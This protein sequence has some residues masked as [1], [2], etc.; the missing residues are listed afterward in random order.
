MWPQTEAQKEAVFR[1]IERVEAARGRP[2]MTVVAPPK[3]FWEA[4]WY[5]QDYNTKNKL[6]L[7]AAAGVFYCNNI[8]HGSFPGQ[9][10]VKAVL[11]GA[12]FLSLVPQ[13][14]APFDRLLAIFD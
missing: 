8:P 12:V 4:E 11:G 2:V 9:E 7:A 5:H 10:A 13:L 1:A 14:V 3:R 6:R